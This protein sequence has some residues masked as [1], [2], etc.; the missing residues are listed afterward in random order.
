MAIGG[1]LEAGNWLS[2]PNGQ[3]QPASNGAARQMAILNFVS[4]SHQN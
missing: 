1:I 3:S 4:E 2:L